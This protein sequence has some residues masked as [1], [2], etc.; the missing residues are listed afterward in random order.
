M[1]AETL[2]FEVQSAHGAT[3]QQALQPP[4]TRR[5]ARRLRAKLV[6]SLFV[7][8]CGGDNAG[9]ALDAAASTD[10]SAGDAG[11]ARD[12]GVLDAAADGGVDCNEADVPAFDEV[13]IFDK[14]TAC[15]GVAV[16]GDARNDAPPDVNFDDYVSAAAMAERAARYVMLG[17]MP[18]VSTGV[19]V[20]ERER[21]QLDLWVRCGAP[22]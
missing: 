10:G 1:H 2:R 20:S 7:V 12:A 11:R 19:R 18:P 9:A 15:H 6:A 3:L 4:T 16:S 8:A 14:C 17:I 22:E 13:E 21:E 5:F